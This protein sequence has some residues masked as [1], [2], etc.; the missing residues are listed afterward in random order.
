M[1]QLRL[2]GPVELRRADGS[3]VPLPGRR[4]VELLTCLTLADPETETRERLA[5][6]IWAGREPEQADGSLRQELARLRRAIGEMAVP[7]AGSVSR[8]LRLDASRLDIDVVRFQAAAAAPGGGVEAISLY[9]GPLLQDFD[10]RPSDPFGEW[11]ARH[12]SELNETARAVL[13]RLLRSGEGSPALSQ[14]LLAVDPLCE[15]GYRFLIRHCAGAGDSARAQAW[16]DRCVAALAG[17]G[18]EPSLETRALMEDARLELARSS[19]NYFQIAR[20]ETAAETTTWLRALREG[21]QARRCPAAR[22]LPEIAD[23]PSVVV[24]PFEEFTS[25]PEP[26]EPPLADIL[27]E[28]TT[29][30]LARL[31][32]LF[33]TSRHSAMAYR[34]AAIDARTIAS[35]LGVRYLV[36]GSL[37]RSASALRCHIRLIDGRTGLHIFADYVECPAE[38]DAE[39]IHRLL[40]AALGKLTPRLLSAEIARA[41]AEHKAPRDVWAA[42][43][44]ARSE[45]LREQPFDEALHRASACAEQ[46]LAFD[47]ENPEA[48]ATAAYLL[49][50]L[51]WA[52]Y[53]RRPL[54]DGARARRL[55][56]RALPRASDNATALAMCS[57]VALLSAWNIDQALSLAE[58]AVRLDANDPH[59]LALLG[60]VR[61]MAGDDPCAS[62]ALIEHAQR[63]S[64]R[65]P[66]TFLW[67]IYGA[68]CRWKLG[69]YEEMEGMSRRSLSLCPNIGWNWVSLAAALALQGRRVEAAEALASARALMPSFT[70]SRF[71]WGARM[72]YGRRFRGDVERDYRNFRDAL[73]ACL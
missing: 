7:A 17:A 23:R 52:R 47:G 26:N 24:L 34:H 38:G 25:T 8:P 18:L 16:F 43:M 35:E 72:V 6:L 60:H 58:A 59:A 33:V 14:R 21:P 73:N 1:L 27:T 63:L 56:R 69:E 36:E 70:P 11:V 51:T 15:E 12:R 49:T 19:A 65:D 10:L 3:T 41:G 2:L 30:A 50:N 66:R 37:V 44:R 4:S 54:R 62:L 28:E 53:S 45:L 31:P 20:P 39:P 5:G 61:R 29:S 40:H 22:P 67:L 57:E 68:S 46:A 55:M 71:Y 48:L 42:L 9:R 32:G 64:P 13:L